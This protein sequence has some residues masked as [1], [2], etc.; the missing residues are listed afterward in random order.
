MSSPRRPKMRNGA[1]ASAA[2]GI[3]P[4]PVAAARCSSVAPSASARV[5]ASPAPAA[6]PRPTAAAR[7]AKPNGPAAR[8]GTVEP[9]ASLSLRATV[10]S[11]PGAASK[12][13][14]AAVANSLIFSRVGFSYSS[15][16]KAAA[17]APAVSSRP[18]APGTRPL[19]ASLTCP[20]I[21]VSGAN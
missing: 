5:L 21:V 18:T 16:N 19:K 6:V 17:P 9:T 15:G 14:L 12:G 10:S 11:Y 20:P 4:N 13:F 1:K 3:T 2:P 7:P 8:N